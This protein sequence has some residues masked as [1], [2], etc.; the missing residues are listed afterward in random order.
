MKRKNAETEYKIVEVIWCD[1]EEK[2]E[3]GWNDKKEMIRY[4]K[5]PCPKMKSVGYLIYEGP[6]HISL[7]SSIGPEECSTIEK[8]PKSFM[9]KL[10]ELQKI[11]PK[12][13][14]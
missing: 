7:L 12:K 5:K 8:I 14:D 3:V 1:A 9:I 11:P 4:A 2:G 10:S 6:E 13:V